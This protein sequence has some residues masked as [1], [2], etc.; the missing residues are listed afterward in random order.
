MKKIAILALGLLSLSLGK[1]QTTDFPL[2]FSQ[3]GLNGTASSIA[4]AGAIGALGGDIMSGNYN[5]A[6]LGL[7]RSSELTFSMGLDFTSTKS[8]TY[9]NLMGKDNHP[10]FNYGNL[11]LVLDFKM[12]KKSDWKHIQLSFGLNR[13][14]NFNNRVKVNRQNLNRSYIEANYINNFDAD[15]DGVL[16]RQYDFENVEKEDFFAS[17]VVS[18]DDDYVLH[19]EFFQE[20]D[21]SAIYDQAIGYR[22]SGYLNEFTMS[23]SA[24]YRN[25]LYLGA[26]LGVPFGEYTSKY[27][28]SESVFNSRGTGRYSYNTEQ[29][30]SVTGFNV[31]FGAILKPVDFWRIGVAVHTPTFYSVDDDYY[32][33]VSYNRTYGGWF[34]PISYNMQSPWRFIGS[35]AFVFG[36]NKSPLSGTLSF[37]CEYADFSSMSFDMDDNFYKENLL[38]TQIDNDYKGA[39]N[40]RVGGELKLDRL[41]L[42]AGYANYGNPY[43]DENVNDGSWN[44]VTFGLGYRDKV[45]SLDLAYVYGRQKSKYYAYDEYYLD[46]D[47]NGYWTSDSNPSEVK[48]SKNLIQATVGFKF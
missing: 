21:N 15:C 41:Y 40:F 36:N 39:W 25:M 10:V 33:E 48:Q 5:P 43:E 26:T 42:R 16:D 7:Y 8:S 17:G 38:N 22:E 46:Q 20:A 45:I 35:T 18:V 12:G 23:F 44:F 37:D 32:Q 19:S 34:N 24:N 2:R 9:N 47:N 1:A 30:L 6:G 14:T 29:D 11:G 31:K 27:M 13:I 3:F 4:K 28:L